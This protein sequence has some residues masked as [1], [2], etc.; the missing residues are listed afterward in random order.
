VT[1]RSIPCEEAR[2]LLDER[3]DAPLPEAEGNALRA[4][5][6]R[7]AACRDEAAALDRVHAALLSMDPSDPGPAFTDRVVGS[8]DRA[9]GA[10]AAAAPEPAAA[11]LLRGLVAASGTCAVAA[12]ALAVLPFDAAAATIEGLVPGVPA[13]SLPAIPA[14]AAGLISGLP[15]LLPAAALLPSWLPPWGAALGALLAAAAAAVPV[16]TLRRAG[17]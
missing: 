13:S 7:C 6:A 4:H 17:R 10:P 3:L 2:A 9:P 1:P 11:R 12:L 14:G 15:D 8:L 16:A 5:L